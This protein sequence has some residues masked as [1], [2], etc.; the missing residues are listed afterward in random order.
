MIVLDD[1]GDGDHHFEVIVAVELEEALFVQD[2]VEVSKTSDTLLCSAVL[3]QVC[4]HAEL[5]QP[6]FAD[7]LESVV[8]EVV[9][10]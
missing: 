5:P 8:D 1:A 9:H 10:P 7:E 4:Q 3:I 2:R 6:D